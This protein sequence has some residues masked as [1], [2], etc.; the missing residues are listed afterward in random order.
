MSSYLTNE[1]VLMSKSVGLNFVNSI[2]C[3][4][5]STISTLYVDWVVPMMPASARSSDDETLIKILAIF[6]NTLKIM[7]FTLGVNPYIKK[8]IPPY[9]DDQGQ[10]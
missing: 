10:D 9:L 6:I 5:F 8:N 7:D 4:L 3:I 1:S 2:G